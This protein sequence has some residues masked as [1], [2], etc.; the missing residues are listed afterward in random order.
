MEKEYKVAVT[1]GWLE[2]LVEAE[3]EAEAIE[4]AKDEF[5][6]T[7]NMTDIYGMARWEVK[8]RETA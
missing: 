2:I 4:M 8:E 5:F 6:E 1:F 3:S 7:Y